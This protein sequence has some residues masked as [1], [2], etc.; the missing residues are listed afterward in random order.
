MTDLQML[1]QRNRRTMLRLG[2]VVALVLAALVAVLPRADAHGPKVA[3]VDP[4]N[5][6]L[7][8]DRVSGKRFAD[9]HAL[10]HFDKSQMNAS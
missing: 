7:S 6:L 3:T 1:L 5:L 8:P 10:P 4:A 2:V 9:F